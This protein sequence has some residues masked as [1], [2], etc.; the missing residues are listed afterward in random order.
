MPLLLA[1]SV[2]LGARSPASAQ[3]S[4]QYIYS[5]AAAPNSPTSVVSGFNKASQTGA[6]NLVPSSPFNERLEGGL[7]AIDGQG[8]FLFVLNPTSDDISMFQIDQAS[9]A[10]SEVSGSPFSV[11]TISPNTPAP[12]QP[13]SIAAEQSGKFLFV[14]YFFAFGGNQGPS[15]V[16]SLAIDTSGSSPVLRP[17]ESILTT[18][19]GAPIQLLTDSKGLRLYVGLGISTSGMLVGGAEVYAIDSATGNLLYQGMA[20][21]LLTFGRDYAIDPQDRFI[22]AGGGNVDSLQSCIISP[23]DGTAST[24]SPLFYLGF[25]NFPPVMLVESSGHFLYI[26][27]SSQSVVSYSIDQTT[28]VLTRVGSTTGVFLAKGSF[29]A[30]PMGSYIYSADL[31]IPAVVHAYQVN[32]QTG[33]LAEILG[34]P[35]SIGVTSTGCCQGLAISGNPVQAI[36]GSAVTIFPSTAAPFSATAGTSSATQVF[37]IVNV[38]NQLLAFSSISI[39]TTNATSFSQTNTCL[40]TLAP[41]ANCS[42][43]ITF[44]PASAGMFTANL[45]VADNAPGSPQTLALNGTGVAA[46]PAV[47]FSPAAPSF[48]STTQGASSAAQTLTVMN[49]GTALLHI[50]SVSLSG[51]NSSDFSF[52]NSCA[53]PV[54]PGANCTILLVFSP[55]AAGQRTANL[56]ITD[57]APASPQTLLL[58]GTGIAAVPV[59]TFSATALAFSPPATTQG[60]SSVA[61]TLTVMNSGNAPLHIATVSLAGPNPSDFSFTNN[62][63]APVAP[64]ANCTISVTFSPIAQGQRTANLMIADDVPGSPQTVS[65]SATANPAFTVGPATGSSMSASV[66]AGQAAQYQLQLTPGPGFTGTVSFTCSGAPL[67]AV[68]QVPANVALANASATPF[69]VTVTTSGSAV[70]PP[71]IPVRLPPISGVPLLPFASLATMFLICLFGFRAF[72]SAKGRNRFLLCGVF[73]ATIFCVILGVA[74]CGGG[75]AAVQPPQPTVTPSGTSTIVITPS[76]MSLSGQPLQLQPIQLTL[77]VK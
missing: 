61:Q 64:A 22:F 11:P 15:S 39:S 8:K 21:T 6:L 40:A 7:M 62:C 36:S 19:G 43:S 60:T 52:T 76:A 66:S 23:V 17:V 5:S 24:C 55:S 72:E 50:S 46:A 59:I 18:S 33:N 71:S 73:A 42:V 44:H 2:F 69:T 29:I 48:P 25:T 13:L 70:L 30:D 32:Q 74:G 75:S 20:D 35:F 3:T 49:S 57:D 37:S 28:G 14:G 58:S 45:Q 26:A 31:T 47:T 54:A 41:N 67:G 56:L 12:S 16:A 34:S 68:C 4:Q 9:G 38:G 27:D 53:T 51:P 77:T 1:L 10:L 65:L 63:T